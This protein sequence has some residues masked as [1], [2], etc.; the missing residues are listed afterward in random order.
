MLRD[1]QIDPDCIEVYPTREAWLAARR[2]L[3]GSCAHTMTGGYRLGGS[4]IGAILGV[5]GAFRGAWDVWSDKLGLSAPDSDSEDKARGRRWERRVLEDYS[6]TT[7]NEVLSP[8]AFAVEQDLW[9][10]LGD[11]MAAEVFVLLRHPALP[12]AICSPDGFTSILARGSRAVPRAVGG[13]EA[14]TARHAAGWAEDTRIIP[15]G[16]DGWQA[17]GWEHFPAPPS[18]VLQVYWSLAVSGLPFWDLACLLPHYKLVWHRFIADPDLQ[19]QLLERVGEWRRAHLLGGEP[20]EIDD[21]DACGSYL[22]RRPR[23]ADLRPGT[24]DERALAERLAAINAQVRELERE[25]KLVQHQLGAAVGGA[26][27]V[28]FGDKARAVWE[29]RKAHTKPAVHVK[30]STFIKVYGLGKGADE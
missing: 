9:P 29:T 7:G 21:S 18:Y 24:A 22:A 2:R 26:K 19:A 4:D 15:A 17:D 30:E 16:W 20:P 13:V 25:K 12:W 8:G 6:E 27:G 11:Q 14:K 1:G 10:L 28:D 3:E 23:G 5:P